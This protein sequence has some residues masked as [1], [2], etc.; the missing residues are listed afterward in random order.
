MSL[1][2]GVRRQDARIGCAIIRALLDSDMDGEPTSKYIR[3]PSQIENRFRNH[4]IA[5]INKIAMRIAV[6]TTHRLRRV[7]DRS[8]KTYYERTYWPVC[9]Y[10]RVPDHIGGYSLR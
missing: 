4:R 2:V 7:D 6:K 8:G 1:P 9:R 10:A 5:K 3:I